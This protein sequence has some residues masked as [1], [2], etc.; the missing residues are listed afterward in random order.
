M[1]LLLFNPFG[2]LFKRIRILILALLVVELGPAARDLV[3]QLLAT[4]LD[5]TG[6][7]RLRGEIGVAEGDEGGY[8]ER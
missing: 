2:A 8:C 3:D 1:L 7:G 6:L 5:R 4:G